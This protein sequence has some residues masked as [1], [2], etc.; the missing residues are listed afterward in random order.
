MVDPRDFN[1]ELPRC[2]FC[3]EVQKPDLR[4]IKG[5]GVYICEECVRTCENLLESSTSRGRARVVTQQQVPLPRQI[6]EHLDKYVIR[7]DYAKKVVAVAV[8]N[9]YKRINSVIDQ[10]SEGLEIEKANIL[11]IGNTGTGKTLIARTIAKILDVPFAIADATSLTEAG[12][13]GEDV[14][15][16]LLRLY[17]VASEQGDLSPAEAIAETERG[18]V[19]IDEID[20]ISR[21]SENPS[22][23]RDVSGEGVQQALLKLLE[24]TVANVPPHGGRKHPQ[25]DFIQIDTTNILF[26]CG[27]AFNGLE[28]IVAKRLGEQVI[29]FRTA[30]REVGRQVPREE[31]LRH[32]EPEDLIKFGLIPELVGRLPVVAPLEDLGEKDLVRILKEP[33]NSLLKQYQYL[34]QKEGVKLEFTEAALREV[35]RQAVRR[36]TG[37]R[38]LRSIMEKVLLDLMYELPGKK[39]N[40]IVIDEHHVRQ[41]MS[42]RLIEFPLP[43]E[44]EQPDLASGGE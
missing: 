18:I 41:A 26:I 2:S 3:G 5:P 39:V 44:E 42:G 9:H 34:F 32:V 43:R 12:Y 6:V 27:G 10:E 1:S 38:G 20:K 28:Q 29:G 35:A 31:L 11:M 19:F 7:Q 37:A 21:K 17:Q 8:Y 4:M 25:D 24:G 40:K 14:E 16:I 30:H 23:T 22:I 15:N 33:R 36:G 13:V